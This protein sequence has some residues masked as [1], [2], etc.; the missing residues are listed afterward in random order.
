MSSE[1]SEVDW[2][3]H[4]SGASLIRVPGGARAMTCESS[5]PALPHSNRET[6]KNPAFAGLSSF[7][8]RSI[9]LLSF[10]FFSAP[11]L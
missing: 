9:L 2:S 6:K 7:T 5:W 1:S 8:E 11:R 10:S 4:V 3:L